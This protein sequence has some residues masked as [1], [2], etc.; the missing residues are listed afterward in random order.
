M[1]N[2]RRFFDTLDHEGRFGEWMCAIP[3]VGMGRVA[4]MPL[5]T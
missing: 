3:P 1:S 2:P 5:P 4:A